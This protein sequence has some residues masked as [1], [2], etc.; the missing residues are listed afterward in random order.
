LNPSM[1]IELSPDAQKD[2]RRFGWDKAFFL[3]RE[4][5][6]LRDDPK[7]ASRLRPLLPSPSEPPLFRIDL[8]EPFVARVHITDEG[9]LVERVVTT[10]ELEETAVEFF[11]E[12]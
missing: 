11:S 5:R 10:Q 7:L 9:L 8:T 1:E 4:L 3:A 12:D 2:I 6:D